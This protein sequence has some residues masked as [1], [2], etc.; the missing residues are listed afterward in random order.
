[1]AGHSK[2]K[3]I[4]VRKGA[5]DAKKGKVFTKVTKE[6]MLAAKA[7]GGDPGT[8]A[9]LRSAI[10]AAK[11]V[12]LPKDKIETAIKKGTGELAGGNFD[13]ITYEGY[14]PGGV[15]ILIEAAT[16]NRNRTVA[17]VR[18]IMSKNG[19]QLGEAG[20]VGWMFDKKGV[21]ELDKAKYTEDQVMEAALEA[22]A[23]D[24]LGEA[25][26]WE[27][28]TAP[29]DFEAV[30][31]A[32]EE[33]GMELLSAEISMLPKTTVDVDAE[34]GRKLM[35]LMDLLDDYDDVQKTHSNFELPE[36]LLAELG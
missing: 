22:G 18:A 11:A 4:Q 10:A 36:E 28:H 1:M 20:C 27:V 3:N 5:Q 35:K 33:A 25:D 14:G 7:G 6:L 29:E 2:W 32:L 13:E 26:V 30:R 8:N 31:Q 16:D 24:V 23:G 19:G 34:T 15:A 17:D 9:R 21:L 12:N